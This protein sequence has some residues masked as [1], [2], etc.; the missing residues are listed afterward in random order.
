MAATYEWSQP[1][2]GVF[3]FS[4]NWN[5][6][7]VPGINDMAYFSLGASG[8]TVALS[9]S[10]QVQKF[11]V[12]TDT[13]TLAIPTNLALTCST[14]T[15]FTLEI[16]RTNGAVAQVVLTDG[17]ALGPAFQASI[18]QQNGSSGTL[19]VSNG[20]FHI[21]DEFT[22]G[23]FGTGTLT[24]KSRGSV[25]VD[26]LSIIGRFL[27]GIGTVALDGGAW[28]YDGGFVVG[29]DGKAELTASNG[30][31]LR[32][33]GSGQS[34]YLGRNGLEDSVVV[35]DDAD[36]TWTHPGRIEI[37]EKTRGVCTVRNRAVLSCSNIHV[38]SNAGAEG[39]FT[40]DSASVLIDNGLNVGG[41]A[42][43]AGGS[44]TVFL[45]AGAKVDVANTVTLWPNGTLRLDNGL[46]TLS[47]FTG[48]GGAFAW[49][50]G[51]L[52]FRDNLTLASGQVLESATLSGT[53]KLT[54]AGALTLASGSA[55]QWPEPGCRAYGQRRR[56]HTRGPVSTACMIRADGTLILGDASSTVGYDVDSALTVGARQVILLDANRAKLGVSTTLDAGGELTGVNG[57]R[58]D[59]GETLTASGQ[60]MLQG[61]MRNDGTVNGPTGVE[62]ALVF[63]DMVS[64]SGSFSGNIT[65]NQGFS[66]GSSPE[67]IQCGGGNLTFSHNST[68]LLEIDG[69]NPGTGFDQ[70]VDIDELAFSGCLELVLHA[71]FG[72]IV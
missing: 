56:F 22:V 31:S 34:C 29:W 64:G 45:K 72:D 30:A 63:D 57:L 66:P 55:G 43:S 20:S 40:V 18:G 54:V 17:G 13:F 51:E 8:Y 33:T 16:G 60:A 44:G 7:G 10:E 28:L 65:F 58:V 25:H 36:R 5:P 59:A 14:N 46:L 32:G 35:L 49:S 26:K 67:L 47:R 11:R 61:D 48:C 3:G 68:L 1:A 52:A 62:T 37:G 12:N 23:R 53:K 69:P 24:V 71:R 39:I 38:G 42:S 6:A 2:G 27:S 41:N 70:L 4:G 21:I 9:A 19:I 50:E 15:T